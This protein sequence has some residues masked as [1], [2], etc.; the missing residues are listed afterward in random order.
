MRPESEYQQGFVDGWC[1][2]KKAYGKKFITTRCASC[3]K[4]QEML[5]RVLGD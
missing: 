3:D 4:G 2:A 5:Q 1:E